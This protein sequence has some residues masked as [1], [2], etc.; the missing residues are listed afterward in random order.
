MLAPSPPSRVLI[1]S[2]FSCCVWS[3]PAVVGTRVVIP[4]F[5][6]RASVSWGVSRVSAERV[7][8]G[9][10]SPERVSGGRVSEER[11]SEERVFGER[12]SPVLACVCSGSSGRD[13]RVF[14]NPVFGHR[15]R[16]G[17][18]LL[19]LTSFCR[20]FAGLLRGR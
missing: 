16:S 10:V 5:R 13:W 1:A 18:L 12:V 9:R 11:V 19:L 17:A 20:S 4:L 3:V 14:H 6:L 2:S 8:E 15:P 7:F